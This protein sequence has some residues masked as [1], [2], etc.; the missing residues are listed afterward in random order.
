MHEIDLSLLGGHLLIFSLTNDFPEKE[1]TS[2]KRARFDVQGTRSLD[3]EA[4]NAIS[5]KQMKKILCDFSVKEF[6]G[7]TS[8]QNISRAREGIELYE[9]T[10][11]VSLIDQC[12]AFHANPQTIKLYSDSVKIQT[13]IP[14]V[15]CF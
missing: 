15:S 12:N 9:S 7:R 6:R 11:V 14:L 8:H 2:V 3:K 5:Y 10:P 13:K 4:G 1:M